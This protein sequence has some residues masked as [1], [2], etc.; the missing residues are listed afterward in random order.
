MPQIVRDQ[1]ER[2]LEKYFRVKHAIAVN[3][4]TSALIATL[5]SMDLNGGEVITTPFTFVATTSS[6]IH[7]GGKPVFVDIK[8]NNSL[9][10][11]R[12]IQ[13]AI[14]KKT[15]AILPVHLFGR[16]CNMTAIMMIAEKHDLV[17]IEDTAQAFGQRHPMIIEG[18]FVSHDEH[19]FL[20]TIGDAGCFSFYKT[21][22][23][24]TFEGGFIAVKEDSK[25]DAEKIRRIASPTANK[26][27]FPE[28]GYNFRMPEP[29][30]LIGLEKIKMHPRS[31]ESELG[32][33]DESNGFYPYVTY[34][35]PFCK[36][37]GIT[38]N[39]PI[40]ESRADQ[41]RESQDR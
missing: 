22:N 36:E 28:L 26:P 10:D 13:A 35:L 1:F 17:V 20:G 18:A 7:A 5:C 29:C 21:K 33:Y 24:S 38:A 32:V 3:S 25:L 34:E 41:I 15:R 23:F 16:R 8:P 14:T 27:E 2:E 31:W 4:G 30:A 40:A 12:K 11:E 37:R 6:I 9:I 39:C 19:M